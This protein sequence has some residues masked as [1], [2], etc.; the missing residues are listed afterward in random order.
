MELWRDGL[1]AFLA[2]TGLAAIF[3]LVAGQILRL[4]LWAPQGA[5]L[6]LAISGHEPQIEKRVR[7]AQETAWSMKMPPRIVV[8]D[9]GMDDMTRRAAEELS[10]WDTTFILCRADDLKRILEE[11]TDQETKHA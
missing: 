4:R 1:I 3:W 5:V 7:R 9:C 8:A 11:L 10:A 2:A 6:V